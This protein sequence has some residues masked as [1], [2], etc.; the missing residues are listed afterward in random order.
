MTPEAMRKLSEATKEALRYSR[1]EGAEEAFKIEQKCREI[2]E[3][4]NNEQARL[5]S[6]PH[7]RIK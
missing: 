7:P 2:I 4:Y 6:L 3:E 5:A 1:N